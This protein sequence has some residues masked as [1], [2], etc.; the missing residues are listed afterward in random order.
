MTESV[1]ESLERAVPEVRIRPRSYR[2][3]KAELEEDMRI[4]AT[5]E[6]LAAAIMTPVRVIQDPGA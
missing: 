4:D 3:S 1:P 6:E 5:P 2:P